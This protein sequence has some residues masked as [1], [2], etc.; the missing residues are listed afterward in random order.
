MYYLFSEHTLTLPNRRVAAIEN[1]QS[2]FD[3]N[4]H[5]KCT[6]CV[7]SRRDKKPSICWAKTHSLDDVHSFHSILLKC[8][9]FQIDC[10]CFDFFLSFTSWESNQWLISGTFEK[11]LGS[12]DSISIWN[13][14]ADLCLFT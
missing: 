13:P 12:T 8:A 6:H 5:T 3:T 4:I 11:V 2:I 9:I 7:Y 10:N 14:A 1:Q